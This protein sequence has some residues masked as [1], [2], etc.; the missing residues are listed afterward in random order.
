[1]TV[2]K[3]ESAEYTPLE[4][5]VGDGIIEIELRDLFKPYLLGSSYC[6][7]VV[8]WW[9][10][11]AHEYEESI[12][13]YAIEENEGSDDFISIA[14]RWYDCDLEAAMQFVKEEIV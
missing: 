1:M 8:I 4:D 13:V 5:K 14:E 2:Q 11:E 7:K 12:K 9:D 3:I 10:T 6:T